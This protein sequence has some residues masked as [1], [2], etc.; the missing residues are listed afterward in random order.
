MTDEHVYC[1][2]HGAYS[3]R[4][5]WGVFDTLEAAQAE[6]DRHSA[7]DTWRPL[8]SHS[9]RWV[10]DDDVVKERN[11]YCHFAVVPADLAPGL[12]LSRIACQFAIE[13]RVLQRAA[14]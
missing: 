12:I 14:A 10:L 13:E 2:F 6:H 4:E 3:D 1:L 7:G 8:P 9:D 5:L 11:W